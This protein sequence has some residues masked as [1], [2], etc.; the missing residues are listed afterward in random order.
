MH[1][2]KSPAQFGWFHRRLRRAYRILFST[3]HSQIGEPAR[4]NLQ[5]F[6]YCT[7]VYG[8]LSTLIYGSAINFPPH[9][10]DLNTC[11]SYAPRSI[12]I[13]YPLNDHLYPYFAV[14]NAVQSH[15]VVNQIHI[16]I[17][18]SNSSSRVPRRETLRNL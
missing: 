17:G 11:P 5:P 4:N 2:E 15:L 9:P 10:F 13:S 16:I 6:N 3:F 7:I 12:D 14:C 8:N 1:L 18:L